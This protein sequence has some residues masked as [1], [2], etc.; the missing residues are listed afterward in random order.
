MGIN[1]FFFI[2]F[3]FFLNFCYSRPISY[4]GGSTFMIFSNNYKDSIYYHY[5]PSSKYSIGAEFVKNKFFNNKYSNLR[6]TYLIE[7]KNTRKS[8]RNLYFESG[9]SSNFTKNFFYGFRGDWE[10]RRI[11]N[12]F[13]I[14]KTY[15]F[16]KSFLDHYF[17][18]GVAP[19]LGDY[20]DLHSWIMLIG[21]KNIFTNQFIIYPMFKF[22]KNNTLL[23]IGF[24][25]K[26]RLDIHLMYRF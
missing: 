9:F 26:A 19:Y 10:T 25:N 8:Q 5:S 14:T 7:R 3:Y 24:S 16:N 13:G 12:G 21:K 22:F 6:F 2:F 17:V 15:A 1:R 11:Y 23:E 18:F 4:S 20:G